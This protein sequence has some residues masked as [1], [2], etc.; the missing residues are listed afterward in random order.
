MVMNLNMLVIAWMAFV[1][2]IIMT[3][4]KSSD[5]TVIVII[6]DY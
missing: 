1:I 5:A 3:V 6:G 2:I 4:K